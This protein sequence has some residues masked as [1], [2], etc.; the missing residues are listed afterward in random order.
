MRIAITACALVAACSFK[1]GGGSGGGGGSP[2]ASTRTPGTIVE[3]SGGMAFGDGIASG[4]VDGDRLEPDVF[5]PDGLHVRGFK[6]NNGISQSTDPHDVSSLGSA[7]GELY[8]MPPD[9]NW[10]SGGQAFPFGVF[11]D[12]PDGWCIAVDGEMFFDAG[13]TTVTIDVDDLAVFEIGSGSG[14]DVTRIVSQVNNTVGSGQVTVADASWLP[15]AGVMCEDGGDARLGV[16]A[17]GSDGSATAIPAARYRARTTAVRGVDMGVFFESE[18]ELGPGPGYDPGPLDHTGLKPLDYNL[19]GTYSIRYQGQLLVDAAGP[20]VFAVSVGTGGDQTTDH[21]RLRVDGAPVTSTWLGIGSAGSGS[22]AG[23][24]ATV[25]LDAGWHAFTL[26]YGKNTGN[27][28]IHFDLDGQPVAADHLRPTQPQGRLSAFPPSLAATPSQACTWQGSGSATTCAFGTIPPS[29]GAVIDYADVMYQVQFNGAQTV[30]NVSLAL[31]APTVSVALPVPATPNEQEL[32]TG[33]SAYNFI[34][35]VG[36][37]AG[38]AGSNATFALALTDTTLS[39]NGHFLG[40]VMATT[41][42]G[43]GAPFAPVYA[44]TSP[45]YPVPANATVDAIRVTGNADLAAAVASGE[46]TVEVATAAD[47]AALASAAFE[48]VPP[49]ASA[50]IAADALVEYRVTIT[51]DGWSFPVVDRVELDYSTPAP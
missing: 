13:T 38:L 44:Y 16:L 6:N 4:I 31:V 15:V 17:I 24:G 19:S 27:A 12:Q 51:T 18:E 9:G 46:V 39:D 11:I 33:N 45:A 28:E 30:A 26:D 35:E 48:P 2:D 22:G 32:G 25:T 10:P 1:P 41:H 47:D 14:S 29:P 42:G 7:S 43:D 50:P 8:G 36:Q 5:V 37:L 40:E 34:P 21:Y 20:H 49:T 23:S 3:G